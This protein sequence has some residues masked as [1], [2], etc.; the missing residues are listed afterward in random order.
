MGTATTCSCVLQ[1][2]WLD[3]YSG[4]GACDRI[5]RGVH[6]HRQSQ[7]TPARILLDRPIAHVYYGREGDDSTVAVGGLC[8]RCSYYYHVG[9]DLDCS[10]VGKLSATTMEEGRDYME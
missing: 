9:V 2:E 8:G 6:S 10:A 7:W 3:V 4:L 1:T 5:H